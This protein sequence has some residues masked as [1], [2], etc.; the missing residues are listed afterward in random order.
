M[1][2]EDNNIHVK[3][4]NTYYVPLWA[5]RRPLEEYE[6]DKKSACYRRTLTDIVKIGIGKSVDVANFSAAN[7]ISGLEK[8]G[9]V[10]M[11]F[12]SPYEKKLYKSGRQY[13]T[14]YGEVFLETDFENDKSLWCDL[15]FWAV[16]FLYLYENTVDSKV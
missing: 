4:G 13:P 2:R 9:I 11:N 14:P 3:H 12:N 7:L 15:T 10:K 16:Q 6:P 5:I 1:L 8:D